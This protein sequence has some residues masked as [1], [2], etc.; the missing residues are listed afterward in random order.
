VSATPFVPNWWLKP[1]GRKSLVGQVQAELV[2]RG[3]P[4]AAEVRVLGPDDDLP[5]FQRLRRVHLTYGNLSGDGEG[6]HRPKVEQPWM[7]SLRF[8]RPV[9]GPLHLGFGAHR[10]LGAFE[11]VDD[12]DG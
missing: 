2:E 10:G 3:L 6:A 12:A 7:L 11:G 5:R 4:E 8:D 1:N 9:A